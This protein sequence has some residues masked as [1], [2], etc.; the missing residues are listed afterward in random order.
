MAR[1]GPMPGIVISSFASLLFFACA[2][3]CVSTLASCL[4]TVCNTAS[5]ISAPP[6]LPL[7]FFFF[8]KKN[9]FLFFFLPRRG[10]YC[11]FLVVHL[12]NNYN[13]IFFLKEKRKGGGLVGGRKTSLAV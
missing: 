11:W 4:C 12:F 13:S 8:K 6:N 2:C 5:E 9:L 10:P 3:N 7:F 1:I